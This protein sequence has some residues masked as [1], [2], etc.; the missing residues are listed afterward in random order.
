MF[1]LSYYIPEE[2]CCCSESDISRARIE[3]GCGGDGIPLV[4]KNDKKHPLCKKTLPFT[5]PFGLLIL[6]IK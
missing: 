4:E 3:G 2:I 1:L 6:C 5:I